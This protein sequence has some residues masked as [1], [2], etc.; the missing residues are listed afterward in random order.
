M[1]GRLL[2]Y[3]CVSGLLLASALCAI[4]SA[5]DL[6][7]GAVLPLTGPVAPIGIDELR[8]VQ[9]AIDKVNAAGGIRGR[10]ITLIT[11]DSQAKPD[12]AV[13]AFNRLVDLHQISVV[14]TG[15]SNVLLATAPLATRKSVVLINSGGQSDRLQSASPYLFNTIPL[16][17]GETE[18]LIK[19]LVRKLGKKTAA[20]IYENTAAGTDSRDDFKNALQ[21]AGGK[22][23]VEEPT[24][25]GQTNFRASLLKAAAA[26]PDVV[27]YA[28]NQGYSAFVEQASQISDLPVGVGTTF[29][30][31]AFEF[32]GAIGWYRS[33]I[34]SVVSPELEKEFV[35]KFK[36]KDMP[37]YSRE[38]F[39]STNIVLKA[40]DHV[41]ASGGSVTGESLR[42]AILALK[43]FDT[44]VGTIT[45]DR[46][47]TA[48]RG[49]EVL[50]MTKDGQ[51]LIG[52]EQ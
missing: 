47:T 7:I 1:I 8:G 45:F 13:L 28:M 15:V 19:F 41:L 33:G 12:I 20:I 40:M 42:G 37:F 38:Y 17:K 10:K 35:E 50:Q 22:V 11:E 24:E 26:K 43:T 30:L 31:P 32:P 16:V 34:K 49:I 25:F 14:M 48:A 9:F 29:L 39:V 46:T 4:A 51:K 23:L 36:I 27:F 5:Q 2:Q 52:I 18:A 3:A 21:A 44:A 6:K